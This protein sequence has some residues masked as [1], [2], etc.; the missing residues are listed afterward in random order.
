MYY[1][2]DALLL[3]KDHTLFRLLRFLPNVLFFSVTAAI[4]GTAIT[5]SHPVSLG[6]SW[7]G[8]FLQTFFVFD[9]LDDFEEYRSG[10]L[11]NA[12]FA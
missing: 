11:Q 3:T 5:V 8:R 9:A 2:T 4:Q 6:S 7:L 12:R 1:N 10:V